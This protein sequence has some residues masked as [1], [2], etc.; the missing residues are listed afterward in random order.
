MVYENHEYYMNS[1]GKY[2]KINSILWSL[3][4]A[5]VTSLKHAVNFIV[6]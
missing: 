6:A 5:S 4:R 1:Q 2:Y 3:K